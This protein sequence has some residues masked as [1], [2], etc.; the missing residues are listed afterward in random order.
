VKNDRRHRLDV[1]PA[2][3]VM[4]S[5]H[6]EDAHAHGPVGRGAAALIGT[7]PALGG[8]PA[9]AD[10]RRDAPRQ[11]ATVAKAPRSSMAAPMAAR[12]AADRRMRAIGRTIAVSML[13]WRSFAAA[14]APMAT[15]SSGLE[16]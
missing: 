14:K 8:A 5:P 10:R 15:R 4:A 13:I 11:G 12:S 3:G 6:S 9:A 7:G 1:R 2:A 16:A